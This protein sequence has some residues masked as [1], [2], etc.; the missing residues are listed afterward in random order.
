VGEGGV[1]LCFKQCWVKFK[2]VCH[3]LCD[4]YQASRGWQDGKTGRYR[5]GYMT[6][7]VPR[8]STGW[9][10]SHL[11]IFPGCFQGTGDSSGEILT[12]RICLPSPVLAWAGVLSYGQHLYSGT[13][14]THRSMWKLNNI[15]VSA[16]A[17]CW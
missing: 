7:L 6:T 16:I 9:A 14:D 10:T 8:L 15:F 4:K 13:L 12:L 17:P 5:N 11:T 2:P 1:L 3:T